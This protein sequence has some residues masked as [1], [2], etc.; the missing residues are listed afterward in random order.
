[1]N[2][3]QK[4]PDAAGTVSGYSDNTNLAHKYTRITGKSQP[5]RL[6]NLLLD[7]PDGFDILTLEQCRGINSAKVAAHQLRHRYGF[8]VQMVWIN[9]RQTNAGVAIG[10]CGHYFIDPENMMLGDAK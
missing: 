5:I 1:M 7:H 4:K 8:N 6:L 2:N 3:S 10:R 9:D